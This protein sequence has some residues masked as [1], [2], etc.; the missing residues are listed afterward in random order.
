V[1]S[2]PPSWDLFT[3]SYIG[4]E[5]NFIHTDPKWQMSFQEFIGVIMSEYNCRKSR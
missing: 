1:S 4:N 3:K 2:L 5:T